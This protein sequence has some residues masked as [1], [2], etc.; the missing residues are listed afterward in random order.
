MTI[1]NHIARSVGAEVQQ[2]IDALK[3]G[4]K[5]Q[6]LPEELWH[7]SFRYYV[8]EDPNRKGGPNLRMIRLDPEKPSLTVTGYIFNKFVHP[9]EDRFITVREAARLQGFP[10]EVQFCG[11]LTSSQLQ[12]GNAV[13]I[14]LAQAVLTAVAEKAHTLSLRKIRALSLF[15][16]A[17]GFDIGAEQVT[18][19]KTRI[20]PLMAVENWNDACET[21]RNYAASRI[22][23]AEMD[24][25]TIASPL[26]FWQKQTGLG[27]APNLVYGGPPCQAFSQA[28][29]QKADD[30]ERGMLIFEFVRFIRDLQPEFFVM[31]NVANLKGVAGGTLLK[32]V[33]AMF[34]ECGYNLDMNVLDATH[35]GAAQRRNRLFIIG[36]R[37]SLGKILLPEPTHGDVEGSLFPLKP[38]QTV[39]QAF[40]R[41]P[42][43]SFSNQPTVSN[44]KFYQKEYSELL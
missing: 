2:R 30:D 14:P 40:E 31:E 43:A 37:Q 4:Q 35:Y 26:D 29:K 16:G 33:V 42:S 5:M 10:D 32:R 6:D 8:K 3:V 11:T 7:P 17:G 28:G 23:V 15:S 9:V 19:G 1:H 39:G 36:C 18:V 20:H 12:V 13:P 38:V 21:L 27:T 25:R 34:E 41:L 22:N 44:H 24:I